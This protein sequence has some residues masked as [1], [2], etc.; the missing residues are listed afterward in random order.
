MMCSAAPRFASAEFGNGTDG[1]AGARMIGDPFCHGHDA[2]VLSAAAW[3]DAASRFHR[4]H[5]C[6]GFAIRAYP[7]RGRSVRRQQVRLES[8]RR[9]CCR[10]RRNGR[11]LHTLV[12]MRDVP[13][14]GRVCIS[15]NRRT[16]WRGFHRQRHARSAPPE[17][18]VRNRGRSPASEVRNQSAI[19]HLHIQGRIR[20]LH[21]DCCNRDASAVRSG[22]G[23][24]SESRTGSAV[25]GCSG[26]YLERR[27][28][29]R[30]EPWLF[31]RLRRI[32]PQAEDVFPGGNVAA[33]NTAV[34]F[35]L[36]RREENGGYGRVVRAPR[37]VLHR[38]HVGGFTTDQLPLRPP[39]ALGAPPT[40]CR[41][42]HD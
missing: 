10:R 25:I 14:H 2:G 41:W 21:R 4:F 8:R 28:F 30:I 31:V 15:H 32:R 11:D 18:A 42:I 27:K 1:K 35:R 3:G 39:N 23:I 29:L 24:K 26:Q 34:S 5:P 36:E 19:A 20:V 16:R 13:H 33:L 7:R 38:L 40:S 9:V 22:G 12:L 6:S 17:R 37:S